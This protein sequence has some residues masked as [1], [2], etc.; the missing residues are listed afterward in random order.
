MQTDRSRVKPVPVGGAEAYALFETAFGTCGIAWTE[1]GLSRVQL[2]EADAAAATN[3]LAA[4]GAR[5]SAASPQAAAAIDSLVRY[6]TGVRQDFADL[7]LDTS[8]LNPFDAGV[9]V[10][11]RA[12]P[13]GCFTTYGE[14][15]R[16]LGQ[17]GAARAVGRAL[18]AN[19]WPIIV[20]CHRVLA[21]GERLGGFSAH[22]AA[23]TKA[24]LLTLE[25]I[26][27]AGQPEL[28]GL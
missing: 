13:Y 20:P 9:F 5:P 4:R 19:P 18:G 28:P 25:G 23:A 15:A 27:R 7:T 26:V 8:G 24:R 11:L 14:L 17:P 16:D 1:A 6:F 2:P 12:L 21:A 10:R 3:R 22:G